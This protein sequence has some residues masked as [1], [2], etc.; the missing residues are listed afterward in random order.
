VA[1][2]VTAS[3][4]MGAR[5]DEYWDTIFEFRLVVAARSSEALSFRSTGVEIS[6]RYSTAFCEALMKDSAMIVGWIPRWR[7]GWTTSRS[8]EGVPF[9]NI[10]SAAPKKLPASTTTL[11]VPSPASTSCAADKSTS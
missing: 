5:I 7:Q 11:V 2:C 9:P 6:V 4:A 3:T 8:M 1:M 10:F